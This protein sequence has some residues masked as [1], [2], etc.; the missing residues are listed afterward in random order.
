MTTKNE[1][2]SEKKRIP[3]QKTPEPSEDD[4]MSIFDQAIEEN[5]KTSTFRKMLR[6]YIEE[7]EKEHDNNLY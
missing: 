4:E 2:R 7:L 3:R 5:I 6:E 1:Q